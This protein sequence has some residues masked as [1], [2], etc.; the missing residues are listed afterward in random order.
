MNAKELRKNMSQDEMA[1]ERTEM[2][3]ER[4]AMASERTVMAEERTVLAEERTAMATERTEMALERTALANSQTLLSY[5]RTAIGALAAGIGMFEFV[6]NQ[7][8]IVLGAIIMFLSPVIAAIG[9]IHY[10]LVRRKLA[11]MKTKAPAAATDPAA[12]EAA[13]PAGAQNPKD[14]TDRSS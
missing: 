3:S 9:V 5:F 6:N 11:R 10:L 7:T 2:S 8:I 14:P 4:T 13:V 12:A 1:Y